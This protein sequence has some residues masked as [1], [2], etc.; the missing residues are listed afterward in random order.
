MMAANIKVIQKRRLASGHRATLT[1]C[2]RCRQRTWHIGVSPGDCP[3][4][5]EGGDR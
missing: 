1:V 4:I 5:T 2:P 3:C